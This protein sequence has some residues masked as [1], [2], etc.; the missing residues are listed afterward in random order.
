[1]L[2]FFLK[3]IYFSG[4]KKPTMNVQKSPVYPPPPRNNIYIIVLQRFKLI[5]TRQ[6]NSHL[7]I[8]NKQAG[9]LPNQL[10]Q[11]NHQT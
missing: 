10:Q 9:R 6:T 11:Q 7:P 3:D 4:T 5:Y 1:L 2:A 8:A